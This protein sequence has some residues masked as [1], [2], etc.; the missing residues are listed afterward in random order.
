MEQF[1]VT[2]KHFLEVV[3]KNIVGASPQ[4]TEQNSLS[5]LYNIVQH[6]FQT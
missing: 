3:S 1:F 4:A 2:N 6:R 5:E